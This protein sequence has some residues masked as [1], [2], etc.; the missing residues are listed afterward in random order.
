MGQNSTQSIHIDSRVGDP[1]KGNWGCSP[2]VFG[3]RRA[4]R[5]HKGD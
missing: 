3:D 4:E 1:P 5:T 2:G